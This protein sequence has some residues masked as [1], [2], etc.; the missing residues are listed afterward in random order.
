M[1]KFRYA[2]QADAIS[3]VPATCSSSRNEPL[4]FG[5]SFQAIDGQRL[6]SHAA[7]LSDLLA[8]VLL[9]TYVDVLTTGPVKWLG[10]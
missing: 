3:A 4:P 9:I 10:L 1:K 2:G 7:V 8:G 5:I 6:S